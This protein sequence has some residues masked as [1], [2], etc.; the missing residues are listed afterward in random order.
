LLAK[1]DLPAA[2]ALLMHWLG[3][4]YAI[5]L[6]DG[7]RSFFGLA[8][9]W[10]QSALAQAHATANDAIIVKFFDFLEANAGDFWE[11]PVWEPGEFAVPRGD[12]L[13]FS[14]PF[15]DESD[16][17]DEDDDVFGAAYE[18]VVYRDSTGD[19]IDADM[20]EVPLPGGDSSDDELE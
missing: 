10:M 18:S 7:P 6:D 2:K 8:I 15:D 9:R 5:R 17:D 11:V 19:D 1:P 4:A 20:L 14:D 13:P 16:P 12:G 3:E